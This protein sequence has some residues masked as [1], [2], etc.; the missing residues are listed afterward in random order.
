MSLTKLFSFDGCGSDEPPEVLGAEYS[1]WSDSLPS[2]TEDDL[3]AMAAED[4][5]RRRFDA[6]NEQPFTS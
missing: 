1:E 2:I 6:N 4:C 3:I 5:E